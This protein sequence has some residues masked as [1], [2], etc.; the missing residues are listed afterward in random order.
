MQNQEEDSNA[1]LTGALDNNDHRG[2]GKIIT[3]R[4]TFRL[5]LPG[6]PPVSIC[7]NWRSLRYKFGRLCYLALLL[8]KFGFQS[9]I[10]NLNSKMKKALMPSQKAKNSRPHT[11][12][13]RLIQVCKAVPV[14]S[15][16]SSLILA[17]RCGEGFGLRVGAASRR[18]F[19]KSKI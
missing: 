2:E 3:S 4:W 1:T 14:F 11:G 8:L 9:K 17:F 19:T 5:N 12:H 18:V 7:E 13:Y 10:A 15:P 16:A 6:S